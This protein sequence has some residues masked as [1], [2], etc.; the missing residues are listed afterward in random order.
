LGANLFSGA[1]YILDLVGFDDLVKT[2]DAV[3]LGE[4]RLDSQSFLGKI[5]GV[6][7]SRVHDRPILAVVGTNALESAESTAHGLANVWAA[8]NPSELHLSGKSLSHWLTSRAE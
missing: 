7:T 1:D 3:V 8:T 2:A 5:V 6:A 4:G